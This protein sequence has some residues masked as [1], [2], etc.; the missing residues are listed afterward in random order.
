LPERF[1]SELSLG[2]DLTDGEDWQAPSVAWHPWPETAEDLWVHTQVSVL[3]SGDSLTI[4]LKGCHPFTM[5]GGAML[6]DDVR[7]LCRGT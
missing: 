5:Q 3:A 2:V 4:L 6:F 1:T 7:A